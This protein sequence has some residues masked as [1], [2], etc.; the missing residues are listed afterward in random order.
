MAKFWTEDDT[1]VSGSRLSDILSKDDTNINVSSYIPD[2]CIRSIKPLV[3]PHGR[4]NLHRFVNINPCDLLTHLQQSMTNN[5]RC[6][7][8]ALTTKPKSCMKTDNLLMKRLEAFTDIINRVK[9]EYPKYEDE[10]EYEYMDRILDIIMRTKQSDDI[11][12]I[13]CN[14]CIQQ[15]LISEEW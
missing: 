2:V 3:V 6:I 12:M 14:Q 4:R 7:L 15:W 8:T 9:D 10:S 11:T 13:R 5:D 1:I